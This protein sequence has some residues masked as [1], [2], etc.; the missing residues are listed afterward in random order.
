MADEVVYLGHRGIQPTDD[1]VQA[2]TAIP[3]PTSISELQAFLG[4]VNFHGKFM[5][6]LSTVLAP[7]YK[8]LRKEVAWR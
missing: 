4:L 3:C 6:N 8:L 5:S 7:L 1:K 2:I